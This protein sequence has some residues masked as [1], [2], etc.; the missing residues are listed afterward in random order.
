MASAAQGRPGAGKPGAAGGAAPPADIAQ[1]PVRNHILLI[2]GV[3]TASL[4]QVLDITIAN[5][6][7]P[8]MQSTLGASPD[9][10]SWVLTSYI[11]ASAVAMPITGWLA[12]RVGSRRLFLISVTLFVLASMLCGMAQNLEEMV[13]FRALQ[14]VGGA[15]IAPLS[16][17]SLLDTTRPSRQPQII[18]LWGMG[19]MIGP[20]LGPVLG[21]YLTETMSWR[22]VFFVNVPVGMVCIAILLSELPSRPIRRRRFDLFGFSMIGLALASLQ[23][24][25]DR[26]NVVD[27]F[28]SM[29]SWIYTGLTISAAWVAVIHL[30]T[31]SNPLFE[32]RL[33]ADVNF[34]IALVFMVVVGVVM[35]ATMA[36]LP[37]MLQQ[38]FGYDVIDTG[39]VLMPRGVGVLVSM[40]LS[41]LLMKRGV[42]ARW[43]VALGFLTGAWSLH[44]MAAWSLEADRMHFI[45]TGLVQGLGIGLVFIPLNATAFS[46]LPPHLR[47]DGSS[48]LNLM[49]SVGSSIGISVVMTLL[50]RGIQ[51]N[52]EQLAA[53]VTPQLSTALDLSSLDRFQQYG[54]AALSVADMEVTRQAAMIAYLNDFEMMKWLSLAAVPLVLLMRKSPRYGR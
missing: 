45:I 11:I 28:T 22:W 25:L 52:H 8:H 46:T 34:V 49:R 35:F 10:I 4:L 19:V 48:L 41:G 42:D 37:P 18:A 7:I 15:F 17:S 54:Q 40:Q 6:A 47:T 36:L 21:G 14:G 13:L 33:F 3:M 20:I 1:L 23:L 24:L 44:E 50:A 16:Q 38:L 39:L 27:W 26:G 12:D 2:I 5:V 31:A 9:T 32:R 29:E 51:R 53:H 43:L 30:S